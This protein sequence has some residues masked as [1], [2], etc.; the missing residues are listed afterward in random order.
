VTDTL[1]SFCP[2]ADFTG[3]AKNTNKTNPATPAG[4]SKKSDI[5][6]NAG[7]KPA[8]RSAATKALI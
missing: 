3:T 6:E 8:F 5:A 2:E 4:R 7:L 1:K